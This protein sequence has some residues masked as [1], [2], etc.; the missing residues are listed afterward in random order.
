[1]YFTTEDNDIRQQWRRAHAG[2]SR[3]SCALFFVYPKCRPLSYLKDI[4]V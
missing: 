1:V 2:N 3:D 4:W